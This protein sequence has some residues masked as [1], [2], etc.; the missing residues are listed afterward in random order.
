MNARRGI[1]A[2][3]TRGS[4]KRYPR[5]KIILKGV[6]ESWFTDL[7]VLPSYKDKNDGYTYILVIVDGLSKYLRAAPLKTKQSQEVAAAFETIFKSGITPA[8]IQSDGGSEYRGAFDKLMK[9][10]NI[11]HY[12]T[13][14]TI[15]VSMA[16]RIIRTI[17]S[18]LWKE[19]HMNGSHRWIDILQDVVTKYNNTRHNTIGM[20]PSEVRKSHEEM[21]L[22]KIYSKNKKVPRRKAKFK[23][24]DMVRISRLKNV[25]EKGYYSTFSTELFKIAKVKDTVPKTYLIEDLKGRPVSGAMYSQELLK[26]KYPN[27]YLVDKVIKFNRN[28]TQAF[29]QWLGM[30]ERSWIPASDIM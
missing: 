17:M 22:K 5:R 20:K 13:Y 2:E 18:L 1:I 9:K 30:K 16:E 14:N 28:K 21:L 27:I 12:R 7:I 24:G 25:F 23:I 6:N 4:R 11:N 19:F 10:Y 15:H 26:T 8:N 3:I 29:V